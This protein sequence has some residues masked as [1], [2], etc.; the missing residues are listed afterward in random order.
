LVLSFP[1]FDSEEAQIGGVVAIEEDGC[2]TVGGAAVAWPPGTTWDEA[3]ESI[4]LNNGAVVTA[5]DSVL[6]GGGAQSVGSLEFSVAEEGAVVAAACADGRGRVLVFN[7]EADI[8]TD[9]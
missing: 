2:V 7:S 9:N 8:T 5:G 3:T 4:V 6:G 1:R